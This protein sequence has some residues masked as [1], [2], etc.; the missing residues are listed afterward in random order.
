MRALIMRWR[1]LRSF[2]Y[3]SCTYIGII[4]LYRFVSIE[5]NIII[6]MRTSV[7]VLYA[8]VYYNIGM[9]TF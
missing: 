7:V 6:Y 2:L 4:L 8:F 3:C 9:Y 1:R 5:Y